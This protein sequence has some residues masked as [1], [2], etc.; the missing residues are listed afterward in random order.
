MHDVLTDPYRLGHPRPSPGRARKF[1]RSFVHFF[2]YHLFLKRKSRRTVEAAGF[3]LAVLP[4]VFDPKRF[5][6]SEFFAGYVG[7]LDLAG[8]R[9]A[10]VGT[11]S[12]I[13]ALAA[14]RAG[15]DR[16]LAVDIN[17]E[18]ARAAVEN[19]E[20]NGLGGRVAGIGSNLLSAVAPEPLFDVII[21]SPPSFPGEPRD[22]ADR[23]W[24][25]GPDYRDIAG[26]FRQ[27]RERLQPDG[28]MYVLFS[29]DSD[30]H[31]LG[32]LISEAGFT[33]R[34]VGERSIVLESFLLYEL[35]TA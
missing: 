27:A 12:G 22:V 35:Q 3:R 23:A 34:L 6:T 16:V 33:A 19:A 8:M 31:R 1:F 14:A 2:S 10:D 18:A 25:A 13:L 11:G 4:T 15:A 21:S 17:P 7:S 9:V 5:L 30:L 24:V 28:R 32:G 20:S 26:L 29:S